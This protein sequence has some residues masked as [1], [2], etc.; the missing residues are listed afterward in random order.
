MSTDKNRQDPL[1]TI[2][3]VQRA[4][5]DISSS[6]AILGEGPPWWMR[7]EIHTVVIFGVNVGWLRKPSTTQV[8]WTNEGLL[9][10]RRVSHQCSVKHLRCAC[11]GADAPAFRQWHDQDAGYGLCP[12]CSVGIT[13]KEGAEYV[14][15][16]YGQPG[17]HHSIDICW[18]YGAGVTAAMSY[19]SH[20]VTLADEVEYISLLAK[21]TTVG[22]GDTFVLHEDNP[23]RM[24]KLSSYRERIMQGIH[25][26]S[27]EAM[28]LSFPSDEKA[29]PR[30][31]R[32]LEQIES[33]DYDGSLA[34]LKQV[35]SALLE[36]VK[37]SK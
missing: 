14:R 32:F 27:G 6:M 22:H 10:A 8:E 35:A 19:D 5:A 15:R 1:V 25:A 11:C 21:K 18:I 4:M 28:A 20:L 31:V 30:M 17:V 33:G 9:A 34:M 37:E 2:K 12:R 23:E 24:A 13:A 26:R 36:K 3:D 7:P 16:T 29:L